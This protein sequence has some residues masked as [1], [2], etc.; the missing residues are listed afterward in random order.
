VAR[1]VELKARVRDWAAQQRCA[2]AMADGPAELLDQVDTFF[3][4]PIGRLKLR[5]LWPDYGELIFYE[6][7]NEA[8]ARLSSYTRVA[9]DRPEELCRALALAL[10]VR[11]VVR[12]HRWLYLVGQTRIHFDQ[13]EQV[14]NF[15]ELEV[16]LRSGQ[17]FEEG[18]RIIADLAEQLQIQAQDLLAGSY[19]DLLG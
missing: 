14:G 2:V 11:G 12:K 15:I 13:V 17:P 1:N 7:A 8:C 10:G 5:Q 6:R 4:V 16:V 18:E 19:V 9:T 3:N